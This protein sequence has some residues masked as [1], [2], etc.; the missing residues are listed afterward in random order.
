MTFGQIHIPEGA[1]A[2]L[3]WA[4]TREFELRFK[5]AERQRHGV[6]EVI[7]RA[8][9]TMERFRLILAGDPSVP[10]PPEPE[11]S[12]PPATEVRG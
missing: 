12:K 3:E 8:T 1:D 11:V 4:A 5:R 9:G 10:P 2:A 6:N 7:V